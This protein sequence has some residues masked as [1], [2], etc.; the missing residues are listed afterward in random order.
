M[1]KYLKEICAGTWS[2]LVGMT[3][4]AK[5]FFKP[6]VTVQYPRAVLPIP[7]RFR[8]HTDLVWDEEKHSHKCILCLSCQ[9]ICPSGCITVIGEKREG[10]KQKTLTQYALDFTKCSLC[11]QCVEV[12]PT[13]ALCFSK[14]FNLA[15]YTRDEFVF[16]LLQRLREKHS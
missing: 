9:R 16:D 1:Y 13:D 3:I 12:C 8:G 14:D 2:L 7:P 4:T 5:F 11:G 6:V 15:G 10:E